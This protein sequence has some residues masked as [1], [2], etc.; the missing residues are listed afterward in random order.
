MG[1]FQNDV[2]PKF[3]KPD[4]QTTDISPEDKKVFGDTVKAVDRIIAADPE[5]SSMNWTPVL[6]I[7]ELYVRT[8]PLHSFP[9]HSDPSVCSYKGHAQVGSDFGH[10]VFADN[11]A[12]RWLLIR[13]HGS[14]KCCASRSSRTFSRNL[15]TFSSF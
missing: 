4:Y 13:C 9:P 8:V 5:L 6:Y 1:L 12:T 15:L 14:V 11:T 3:S 7:Y 2:R 10:L